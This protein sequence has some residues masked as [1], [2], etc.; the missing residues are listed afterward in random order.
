MRGRVLIVYPYFIQTGAVENF[1]KDLAKTLRSKGYT[2]FILTLRVDDTLLALCP[3]RGIT[4]PIE[5]NSVEEL[6]NAVLIRAELPKFLIRMPWHSIIACP[7]LSIY[8]SNVILKLIEKYDIDIVYACEYIAILAT[9]MAYKRAKNKKLKI[10]ASLHSSYDIKSYLKY[11]AFINVLKHFNKVIVAVPPSDETFKRLRS[12]LENVVYAPIGIDIERFKPRPTLKQE[13]RRKLGLPPQSIVFL[14]IARFVPAK[15]PLRV[16]AT[17]YRLLKMRERNDLTLVMLGYGEL[18]E[19]VRRI[20]RKLNL[21]KNVV[22]L[23]PI[24]YHNHRLPMIYNASDV[25]LSLH[26]HEGT[27][28]VVLEALASGLPV[29][30]AD[31]LGTPSILRKTLILVDPRSVRDI[32][33]AM[34]RVIGNTSIIEDIRARARYLIMLFSRERMLTRIAETIID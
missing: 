26:L 13:F 34:S 6:D 19:A 3:P 7:A 10:F 28:A 29:I 23:K 30:H 4:N 27:N 20:I 16:I 21:T 33:K 24:S 18:E 14:Y 1:I 5:E 9:Y 22:L 17:F 31:V 25:F 15:N 12:L 8:L 2:V 11:K 32:Y